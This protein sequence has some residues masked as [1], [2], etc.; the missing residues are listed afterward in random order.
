MHNCRDAR[1]DA[2]RETIRMVDAPVGGALGKLGF[3]WWVLLLLGSAKERFFSEYK[4][5]GKRSE[6][7]WWCCD[8]KDLWNGNP[9]ACLSLPLQLAQ[10]GRLNQSGCVWFGC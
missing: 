4:R 2:V 8:A 6:W 3:S 7:R 5:R 1:W 10:N 9:V